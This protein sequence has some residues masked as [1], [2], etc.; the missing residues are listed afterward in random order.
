MKA[1]DRGGAAG[2]LM[3]SPRGRSF[4]NESRFHHRF[5][6]FGHVGGSFQDTVQG[7]FYGA[8]SRLRAAAFSCRR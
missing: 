2:A 3:M 7:V 6:D 4:E 8:Q 5:C 1:W